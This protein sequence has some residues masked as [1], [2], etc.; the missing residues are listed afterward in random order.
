[1]E[2]NNGENKKH[3]ITKSNGTKNSEVKKIINSMDY[4][5]GN[6]V[7]RKNEFI[8]IRQ[9]YEGY[10]DN[11][12]YAYLEDNN[13]IGN[14]VDL[15]FTPLLKS[16]I[17]ILVGLMLSQSLEPQVTA[18]DKDTI[19]KE[20]NERL[21]KLKEV[22]SKMR[23]FILKKGAE[24]PEVKS[25]FDEIIDAYKNSSF[26]SSFQ[27][28]VQHIVN[29]YLN[30][31]EINFE[32]FM[33]ELFRNLLLYKE[34]FYREVPVV[35]NEYPELEVCLPE[36]M[37]FMKSKNS[38]DLSACKAIVYR[39]Y[40]TKQQVLIELGRYMNDY[41]KKKF[42]KDQTIS[43]S[44][45]K[46]LHSRATY[47]SQATYDATEMFYDGEYDEYQR[48]LGQTVEVLHVEYK[49]TKEVELEPE[50]V[51]EEIISKVTKKKKRKKM[52]E[53]RKSGYKIGGFYYINVGEDFNAKRNILNPSKVEFTY[54]GVS[55][56]EFKKKPGSIGY[57]LIDINDKMDIMKYMRDNLVA[58]SG[59]NGSRI[60]VAAI[61]AFLGKDMMARLKSFLTYNKQGLQLID[62]T[63]PGARNGEFNNY[64]DF[65]NTVDGDALNAIDA[66]LQR[67]DYDADLAAGIN[68]Q[69][70][71]MM[72]EREAVSNVQTG[73]T[74]ISY[75][76]KHYFRVLDH[77]LSKSLSVLVDNTKI[78]FPEGISGSY[79]KG[80]NKVYF[81]M[82]P[83]NYA[84]SKLIVSI[85]RDDTDVI[86]LQRLKNIVQE[87]GLNGFIDPTSIV[88]A[89]TSRSVQELEDA[90][91]KGMDK[92]KEDKMKQ[93][94]QK[95]EEDE[96]HIKELEKQL[97]EISS[98]Y[99]AMTKKNLELESKKVD[100]KEKEVNA[101]ISLNQ[102]ELIVEKHK[103]DEELKSIRERTQ[104]EREQLYSGSGNA[105]EVRN[106]NI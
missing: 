44:S 1:M 30:N 70:R 99:E 59:V 82:L 91:I 51:I 66:I 65:N 15:K 41:Q 68:P 22:E 103:I 100:I 38:I 94:Q 63:Q 64:G 76:T 26:V 24:N 52:I 53:V 27:R 58:N 20:E 71:G 21:L 48:Y 54:R 55:Y 81:N 47:I 89:V 36:D 104:L 49:E 85:K 62:P 33:E 67:L 69:M 19:T 101:K 42:L 31:T 35:K 56:N 93:M 86:E 95:L 29:M 25:K 2:A 78:A 60:N 79:Y 10:R 92:A 13:G 97:K 12:D 83:V 3:F 87:L 50:G 105:K 18:I 14:P 34:T 32:R 74:M 39:R 57:S 102:E 46:E 106:L 6:L 98:K 28:D 37:F 88:K 4:Y 73:I 7:H 16:R 5:I 40:M 75:A 11:K 90:T 72:E 96:Q 80:A 9:Y 17:D 77:Q 8:K 84:P 23:K 43:V 61:P 45:A